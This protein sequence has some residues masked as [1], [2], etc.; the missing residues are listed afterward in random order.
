MRRVL[1]A[2][3]CASI[4]VLVMA[5][6]GLTPARAIVGG[7]LEDP[8]DF[9]YFVL[10]RTVGPSCGG[11]VIDAWWVLTAAHCVAGYSN[12]SIQ[13]VRP[14]L[15]GSVSWESWNATD[16]VPHPLWDGDVGHGHDLALIHLAA[17]NAQ[18]A[19]PLPGLTAIQVGSPWD[20]NAYAPGAEATIMGYGAT[21]ATGSAS[22]GLLAADTPI[23]SDAYMRT[24]RSAWIDRL[25]IGAGATNQSTCY[26][27]S[28]GPL[29]VGRTT[30]QPV[31]IGVVSFGLF[32]CQGAA[33]FDELTGPQLAWV[34]SVVPAIMSHWG[35]CTTPYGA[36]Y[37][38]A[39][40]TAQ[41]T[42]GVQ[43]DGP[44]YWWVGCWT[45]TTT[46]PDLTS[47]TPSE[48]TDALQAV[49]LRLGTVR[50]GADPGCEYV[51][52]V[53]GQNPSAGSSVLPGS[54]V[55]I[56]VGRC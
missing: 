30:A 25:L 52:L 42:P 1:R 54:A 15:S 9:P 56:T 22:G 36:G 2:L 35:V 49:G 20:P 39:G 34:A 26:G 31:L 28:G 27:D 19:A 41:Y 18:G 29:V 38:V 51:G 40:Y 4:A 24:L 21:S 44:Y 45:P 8:A 12:S 6:S 11:S 48:A 50:F 10:V 23:L 3:V 46:V 13:V 37:S 32:E 55:S 43:R 47:D 14:Q 5:A 7:T 17:G 16:V 33:A 53:K